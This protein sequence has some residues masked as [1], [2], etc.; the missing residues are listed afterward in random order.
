M[1]VSVRVG[2]CPAGKEPLSWSEYRQVW[3]QVS[4][5]FYKGISWGRPNWHIL[6]GGSGDSGT[7]QKSGKGT[8]QRSIRGKDVQASARPDDRQK[9][10]RKDPAGGGPEPGRRTGGRRGGALPPDP[11][12]PSSGDLDGNPGG[13]GWF[14]NIGLGT[15]LL[16]SFILLVAIVGGIVGGLSYYNLQG[17]QGIVQEITRQRVPVVRHG[18][19]MERQTAR[20]MVD[21]K[22]FFAAASDLNADR[23]GMQNAVL[24]DA[25]AISAALNEL[26]KVATEHEDHTLLEK[27]R[28]VRGATEDYKVLYDQALA[29]L[30]ENERLE[31][32]MDEKGYVLVDQ[33]QT[34]FET[35]SRDASPEARK[36]L[37]TIVDIW[38]TALS[39]RQHEQRYMRTRN[40]KE[41][42]EV[43]DNMVR[44]DALY[45]ALK[46]LSNSNDDTQRIDAAEKAHAEYDRTFKSWVQN[47]KSLQEKL[48]L[49]NALGA[50]VQDN[51]VKVQEAGWTATEESQG[52][53]EA[54]V[55]SAV[56]AIA[57]AV[58]I[59]AMVGIILGLLVPRSIVGPVRRM[60]AAADAIAS[61]DLDQRIDLRSRDEIGRMAASFR[62]MVAYM[63]DMAAVASAMASGDLSRD[64]EPKSERDVLGNAFAEMVVS[65]RQVIGR[66]T[67]SADQLA[68]SSHEL[69]DITAQADG[70]AQQITA[71]AQQV[72]RGAQEQTS[73]SGN[74]SLSMDQLARAID[75]IAAGAAEQAQ[76]VERTSASINRS[77]ETMERV[78]ASARSVAEATERTTEVSRDGAGTVDKMVQAMTSIKEISSNIATK[79][80]QVGHHSSEIG[81]IV[82]TIDDIAGQTNLLALNAAI[83]AARAGEQGR[84]FAVVADEV[85]KLA[86]RS[87]EATKEIASL[88]KSAQ[89]DIAEAV[90]TVDRGVTEIESGAHLSE[91]AGTALAQIIQAATLTASQ[92]QEIEKASAEMS[93][94][95]AQVVKAVDEVSEVVEQNTAATEQMAA[96]SRQVRQAIDTIAAVSEEN[97]AASE[98]VTAATEEMAAQMDQVATSA[99]QLAEMALQLQ[100][101]VASFQQEE[102]VEPEEVSPA[103]PSI[104]SGRADPAVER[105]GSGQTAQSVPSGVVPMR[106]KTDWVRPGQVLGEEAERHR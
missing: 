8:G 20:M 64:V 103:Q 105:R 104:R 87:S 14:Q 84:G 16:A 66:V 22:R 49:M 30:K 102:E 12:P 82:E 97:G 57:V 58:L 95:G 72:A 90:Q 54:V 60:A 9:G 40:P 17:V 25:A 24:A 77:T 65:F 59:A 27:S 13:T 19:D 85:R 3:R 11:P 10:R 75:Q 46:I 1:E 33:A 101:A 7:E 63:Q 99:Q 86:E 4:A 39:I 92:A 89:A 23:E 44:L 51:A 73:S 74:T 35:K 38:A 67:E 6:P 42:E 55:S 5:W 43:K 18:T 80:N 71:S 91:E 15:R 56:T 81:K 26:D 32:V 53:A 36:A 2:E 62:R 70:A 48:T 98:Q 83:E 47:D 106:R 94:I 37:T 52:Q 88:I 45:S 69:S 21:E 100:E 61:G 50:V 93:A 96:S 28:Q 34:Y 29:S 31:K 79:I 78:A 41:L 68:R 76:A